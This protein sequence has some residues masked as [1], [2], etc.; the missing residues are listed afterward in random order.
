LRGFDSLRFRELC[1]G[2]TQ[3]VCE[4]KRMGNPDAA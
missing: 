3:L 4:V 1:V 2:L